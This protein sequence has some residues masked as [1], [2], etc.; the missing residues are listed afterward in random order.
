VTIGHYAADILVIGLG[1]WA[2]WIG[3][4]QVRGGLKSG[5]FYGRLG[6]AYHESRTKEPVHFW[7][8]VALRA[9]VIPGGI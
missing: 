8:S 7:C 2:I 9:L 6:V 3:I 1:L 5:I 4:D